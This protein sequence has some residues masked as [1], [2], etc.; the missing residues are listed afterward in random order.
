MSKTRKKKWPGHRTG[1]LVEF[2]QGLYPDGIPLAKVAQQVGLAVPTLSCFFSRDN[3]HLSRAEE[4]VKAYGYE[5]RLVYRYRGQYPAGSA[6]SPSETVGN[7]YGI[8]EYCHRQKR[9]LHFVATMAGIKRQTLASALSKG[10]ILLDKLEQVT[11][12]LGL[13]IEWTFI[14]T[15]H[16]RH[17]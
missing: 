13:D 2:L 11:G 16:D 3:L 14:P 10:D 17:K 12:S 5:L 15:D 9:T 8:E 1:P 7:L 6:Y 4:I